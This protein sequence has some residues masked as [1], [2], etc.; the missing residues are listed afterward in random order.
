MKNL[1]FLIV[2]FL[3]VG[4]ILGFYF[5]IFLPVIKRFMNNTLTS[6][7]KIVVEILL[8]LVVFFKYKRGTGSIEYV[9]FRNR[10]NSQ[11]LIR[12]KMKNKFRFI[13][14]RNKEYKDVWGEYRYVYTIE[15]WEPI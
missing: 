9:N 5:K 15:A 14:V 2:M 4:F 10:F 8:S 6:L 13:K 3:L 7:K 11:R 12:E 1:S